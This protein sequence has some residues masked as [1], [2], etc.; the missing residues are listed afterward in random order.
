MF[1]IFLSFFLVGDLHSTIEA[2]Q[3]QS[4]KILESLVYTAAQ[5]GAKQFIEMIF[6]T[7]AQRI[8]F[9]SYKDRAPLPED[10]ARAN[11]HCCLAQYLEDVTIR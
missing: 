11:G 10:V 7:S 1:S 6:N 8:V 4:V 3:K 2:K 5:T 9:D